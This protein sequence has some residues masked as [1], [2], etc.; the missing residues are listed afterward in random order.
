MTS[1][2]P[3]PTD[4]VDQTAA[5]AYWQDVSATVDGMLGGISSTPGYTHITKVDIQSSRNFLAKLGFGTRPGLRKAEVALEGG[6]G[7]VFFFPFP[8]FFFLLL[9]FSS[10]GR[11]DWYWSCDNRGLHRDRCVIS[12]RLCHGKAGWWMS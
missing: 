6:A 11:H 4:L 8:F 9:P 12:R 10:C 5:K 7:Y 1:Q 3:A 2:Q